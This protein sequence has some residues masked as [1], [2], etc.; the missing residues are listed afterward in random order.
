MERTLGVE[1]PCV[2]VDLGE[3]ERPFQAAPRAGLWRRGGE[4]GGGGGMSGDPPFLSLPL[5]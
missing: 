4:R 1:M 2:S 3:L 5:F